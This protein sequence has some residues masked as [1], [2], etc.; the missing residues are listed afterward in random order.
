MEN[1]DLPVFPNSNQRSEPCPACDNCLPVVITR[2]PDTERNP[3]GKCGWYAT[4]ENFLDAD[5]ACP[6]NAGLSLTETR[7]VIEYSGLTMLAR[8]R[9][10]SDET[11]RQL[12]SLYIDGDVK[13]PSTGENSWACPCC[14]HHGFWSIQDND[15]FCSVC[16]LWLS[17]P[18]RY[19]TSDRW[20][21]DSWECP[22]RDYPYGHPLRV[23]S[24]DRAR[25]AFKT[26][27]YVTSPSAYGRQR[28]TNDLL[29]HDWD[30]DPRIF[31][32][33]DWRS[34]DPANRD[35]LDL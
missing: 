7:R 21:L 13:W 33:P 20:N 34:L 15:Q 8:Y 17:M 27:G 10:S 35:D 30:K 29:R 25:L 32:D 1:Q 31:R 23:G 4:V 16:N 5:F 14:G 6:Y 12:R 9:L 3:C 24:I 26:R 11:R 18:F 2:S 19:E 22:F 28:P